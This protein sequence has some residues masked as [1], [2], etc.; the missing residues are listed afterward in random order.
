MTQSSATVLLPP[1]FS[2]FTFGKIGKELIY[3]L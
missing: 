3:Y 2:K 1:P